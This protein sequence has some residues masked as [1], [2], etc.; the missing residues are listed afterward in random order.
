MIANVSL[1]LVSVSVPCVCVCVCVCLCLCL[2]SCVLCLCRVPCLGLGLGLGV[3]L[4]VLSPS[5]VSVLVSVSVS[6]SVSVTGSVQATAQAPCSFFVTMPQERVFFPGCSETERDQKLF[7]SDMPQ[8][9]R[10]RGQEVG[11]VS[12]HSLSSIVRGALALLLKLLLQCDNSWYLAR[13]HESRECL[14]RRASPLR[15]STIPQHL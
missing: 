9:V 5:H 1:C 3:G 12:A 7:S 13:V 15:T 6:A 2:V 11:S 10:E 8:G 14:S 4:G